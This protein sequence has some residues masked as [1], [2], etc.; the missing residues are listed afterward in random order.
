MNR[1]DHNVFHPE[2][3]SRGTVVA[4]SDD[5]LIAQHSSLLPL[6]RALEPVFRT[7]FNN[8]IKTKH[9]EYGKSCVFLGFKLEYLNKQRTALRVSQAAL[10]DDI[11]TNYKWS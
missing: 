11:V 10:V 1:G 2:S 7:K 9:L 3:P 4:F 6:T 5:L 8:E